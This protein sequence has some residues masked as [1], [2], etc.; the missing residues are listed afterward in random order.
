MA[1]VPNLSKAP[2]RRK[3]GLWKRWKQ[4]M[5][6]FHRWSSIAL[7]VLFAIWF[8]SGV[9]MMYVPFPSFRAEERV[10]VAKPIRWDLVRV[11][12]Q[13]AL[14]AIGASAFPREMRLE[15]TGGAPVYRMTTADG[16]RAV[17]ATS[18]AAVGPVDAAEAKRIASVMAGAPAARAELVD[19]DQWVVTRAYAR[20]APFWRVRIADGKGTDLYVTRATGEVVQNTDARERFWNWLGAVPHWIYFEVLRVYQEPWRQTVIWTSG[21]GIVGAILGM[22]IGILRVR[23]K[24]RYRSGSTSPYRGWMKWHHVTGLVG[25]LFLVTWVFSGWLSMSPFG[26]MGGDGVGERYAGVQ[27]AGF[28]P[29][30]DMAALARAARGAPEVRFLFVDSRP[31]MIV[32]ARDGTKRALDGVSAAVVVPTGAEVRD[33]GR[34]AMDGAPLRDAALLTA[35]DRHWYATGD[36]RRDARPLPVWRLRFGDARESWLYVDPGTGELL[37]QSNAGRRGYRWLF[38]ALHSFD[39]PWLLEYRLLRDALMIVLSLAGLIVSVSGVVVGWRYLVRR[40]PSPR[41]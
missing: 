5:Y 16:R 17:S 15:M 37:A 27:D 3:A 18:G 14:T 6:W 33:L 12:P 30:T 25:G 8:I 35:Y 10:A 39:L 22:W 20:I 7:C 29:S 9:V 13:Q 26:G 36:P 1:S 32:V 2:P 40:P 38:S 19:H 24:R 31:R 21:I 23:V 4:G 28:A 11:G 41:A 34:R